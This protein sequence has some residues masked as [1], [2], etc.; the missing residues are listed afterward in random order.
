MDINTLEEMWNQQALVGGAQPAEA[1]IAR[2]NSE[3]RHAQRRVRGGIVLAAFVLALGWVLLLVA[4]LAGIKR[5]S[6]IDLVSEGIGFALYVAF[7]A[8]AGQ[9]LRAI[10]ASETAM[11]GTLR[12]STVAVLRTV[13]VQIENGRIAAVAMPAVI[14][15]SAALFAAKYFAGTLPGA[16]AVIGSLIT[17]SVGAAIGAAMWRRHRTHLAPRRTELQAELRAIEEASSS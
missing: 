12:D 1:A 16:G 15:V 9:T 11:G 4:Y 10:R 8:R 3:I 5:L 13:E 2:M 7:F 17:V 6:A 14:V